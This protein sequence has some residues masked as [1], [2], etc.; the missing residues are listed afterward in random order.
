LGSALSG[1]LQ[2]A[3]VGRAAQRKSA[4]TLLIEKL[5]E[6]DEQEPTTIPILQATEEDATI[7]TL[8]ISIPPL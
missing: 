7:L 4:V 5:L 2:P 6:G 3:E 8:A 1:P